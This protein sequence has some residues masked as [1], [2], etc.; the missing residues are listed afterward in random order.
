MLCFFFPKDIV[1]GVLSN[2]R[3]EASMIMI[4]TSDISVAYRL[5]SLV[6]SLNND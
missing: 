5:L 2:W 1:L 4:E 3:R 6:F